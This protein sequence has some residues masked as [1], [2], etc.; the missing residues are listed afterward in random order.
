MPRRFDA[1]NFLRG[2]PAYQQRSLKSTKR[3]MA[4]KSAASPVI[5]TAAIFLAL[6]AIKTSK[7]VSLF[8]S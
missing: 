2:S 3:R 4:V 7:W 1:V 5:R 6:S 8:L